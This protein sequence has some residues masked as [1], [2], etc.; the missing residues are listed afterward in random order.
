MNIKKPIYLLYKKVRNNR[1]SSTVVNYV[2]TSVLGSLR[3]SSLQDVREAISSE[4]LDSGE[5]K[6]A[7]ICDE[8]TWKNFSR[9]CKCVFLTPKDWK[10]ILKEFAPDILFCESAWTGIEKY[11][12]SWRGRIYKNERLLC[13]NRRTLL[14][15][16]DYCKK[17]EIATVFW[18]KEDPVYFDDPNYNYSNTAIKCDFVFTTAEEC[19][20]RYKALGH[21]NVK[22]LMFGISPKL[23]NVAKNV[24]KR[25]VAVFAGSWYG[26]QS[27][28]CDE[29]SRMFDMVLSN[30]IELEIYNRQSGSANSDYLFPEKYHPY[31]KDKVP[32]E[33]LT[34]IYK[35]AKY[36]INI[37]TVKNSKTMFARRVFEAMA[38]GCIVISNESEG[39]RKHFSN[40]I[41]FLDE[42][43]NHS[44]EQE[45][46]HENMEYV[47]K[48]HTYAGRMAEVLRCVKM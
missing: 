22:T 1:L 2:Y 8:M 36:V 10:K 32:Y 34:E 35:G 6:V 41:W 44:I 16:I 30:N 45:I 27:E 7:F 18:N 29:L 42:E 15:I 9:E 46:V 37:N 48:N 40:R 26:D 21:K 11:K 28:R 14:K 4:E 39:M 25:N 31:I 3:K 13:E 5:I 20:E 23:F 33:Q 24:Q 12:N 38:C 19:V 47:L 43:F 17:K